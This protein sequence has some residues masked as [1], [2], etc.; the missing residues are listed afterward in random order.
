MCH[1]QGWALFV[2]GDVLLR[3]DVAD[4]FAL[5]DARYAVQVVQHPPPLEEG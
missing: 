4:V 2:D 3:A 5:A 1:Y